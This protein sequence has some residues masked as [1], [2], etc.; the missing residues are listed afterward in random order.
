MIRKIILSLAMFVS[1]MLLLAASPVLADTITLSLS[2]P[3]QSA[4][5]GSTLTFDATVSAPSTNAAPVFLNSDNYTIDSP[6]TL[7]D[8][9][10]FSSPLSLD[11]GD[12]Y[13]GALFT[14][15]LPA[16]IVFQTYTGS[17]EILGGADGL[18]FDTLATT[19]FQVNPTPEP[20]TMLLLATGLC[21]SAFVM[22]RKRQVSLRHLANRP[23]P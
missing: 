7:D 11:P 23:I 20:G 15:T 3:V 12:S 22:Y 1:A 9:D 6:L 13:T 4:T 8:S 19:G 17:F 18:A 16:D 14:V 5:P 21:L 10:F 2:N